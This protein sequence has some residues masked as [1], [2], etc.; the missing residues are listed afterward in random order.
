[1][2]TPETLR[3]ELPR[4]AEAATAADRASVADLLERRGAEMYGFA[5]HLGLAPEEA[6]DATQEALLRLWATLDAGATVSSAEPWL[7]RTLYRICMDQHRWHRRVQGLA[8]R[9]APGPETTPV[10]RDDAIAVWDAVE[11]LPE[12]QRLAVYLRYRADLPYEEI[13]AVLGIAP[14]SARSHV[15]RALETLRDEL[16]EE[17]IR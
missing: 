6:N 16:G 11:R 10:D 12:R 17:G 7:F 8:A 2:T 9:L 14:V 13:G 3:A 1:M 15:S 5:R 4:R